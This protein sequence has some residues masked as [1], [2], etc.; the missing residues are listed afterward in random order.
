MRMRRGREGVDG[1]E[2]TQCPARRGFGWLGGGFV[3]GIAK[4]HGHH[5]R[6]KPGAT[7]NH[8]N[9]ATCPTS[10]RVCP[11]GAEATRWLQG[12][13]VLA[14]FGWLSP[15]EQ[16]AVSRHA[17]HALATASLDLARWSS[18]RAENPSPLSNMESR[19]MS[20]GWSNQRQANASAFAGHTLTDVG[21]VAVLE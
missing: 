14:P 9:T 5:P 19:R 4:P 13:T 21:Q 2:G 17:L 10:E 18:S 1:K 11:A 7:E 20:D 6:L 12:T 15:W 8:F 16:G 3:G